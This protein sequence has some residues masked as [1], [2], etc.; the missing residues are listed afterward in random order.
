MNIL[1]K[2]ENFIM[3]H[4]VSL[5]GGFIRKRLL[6]QCRNAD[7]ISEKNLMKLIKR[8]RNTE[9]GKK[10]N[11]NNIKSIKDYQKNVP[12]SNYGDYQDYISE[13]IKTGKQ[14]LIVSDKIEFFARTSGSTGTMKRIPVVKRAKKAY[15]DTVAMFVNVIEREM[16]KRG[17]KIGRGLNLVEEES[18][19]TPGGIT[20]GI[21]SSYTIKSGKSFVPILTCIPEEALKCNEECDMKYLKAFYGLKE[22][23]LTFISSVFTSNVTDLMKYII[24]N[25]V[26]LIKDIKNGKINDSVNIP[27]DIKKKLN[28]K[29][30]PDPKRAKE[31]RIIMKKTKGKLMKRIWPKLSLI[32]GIGTGEFSGFSKKLRE[33]CGDDVSFFNETYSASECLIANSLEIESNEYLLLYDNAFFEFIP[34][35]YKKDR[36]LLFNELKVGELYEIVITSL[37]GL[38]RYRIKDVIRVTRYV[39][40]V[41]MIQFAYRKQQLIN[42]TGVK[43]TSEHITSAISNFENRTN[44]KILEYCIYPDTKE[45]PW[46]MNLFIETNSK[47]NK[48][49]KKDLGKIFDEELTKENAEHGR[50]LKIGE[51][52]PT[53]INIVQNETFKKYRDFRISE[54]ASQNQVKS[55]RLITNENQFV[56]FKKSI[57]EKYQ[58]K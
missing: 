30:K 47:I 36:P 16:S 44:I 39:E 43:L 41:P 6:K 52:S 21:I 46:R 5:Y 25:H 3:L 11:F 4:V 58:A 54:G 34:I 24:D 28:K 31:L 51:T 2:I 23:N 1:V 18:N 8:N 15:I 48:K 45:S 26:Q 27:E 29:L 53:T 9:Y 38:Y 42:I 14:N 17:H 7:K 20:E 33:Y 55:I 49:Q 57:I 10:Y 37:S 22:K 56:F 40:K 32:I 19:K 50:M 13:T 35:D 12:F